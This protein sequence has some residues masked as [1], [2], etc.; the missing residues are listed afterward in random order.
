[1]AEKLPIS[2]HHV[3][4]Y[5]TDW[6]YLLDRYGPGGPESEVGVSRAIRAILHQR[7]TGLRA[8]EDRAVDEVK[9]GG[10]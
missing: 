10:S 7:V 2:K 5:D 1:M 9:E 3:N 4:I 6:E 8:K